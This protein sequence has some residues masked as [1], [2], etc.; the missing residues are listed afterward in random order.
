[1]VRYECALLQHLRRGVP[2][3]PIY[4]AD[5]EV[6]SRG[7]KRYDLF[8]PEVMVKR[9]LPRA[10]HNRGED[11]QRMVDQL[12]YFCIYNSFSSFSECLF[13]FYS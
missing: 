5:I 6:D 9:M 7:E 11:A 1:M 2:V 13:I 10:P 8:D 12:R 4:L 3:V